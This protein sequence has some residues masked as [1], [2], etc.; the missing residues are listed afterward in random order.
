MRFRRR[1][2]KAPFWVISVL[3]L[4]GAALLVA[5][6]QWR[7][8]KEEDAQGDLIARQVCQRTADLLAGRLQK[9]FEAA[10]VETIEGIDHADL[11]ECRLPQVAPHL[12]AGQTQLPYV[13]RFFLWNERFP[14]A[15]HD[16]VLFYTPDDDEAAVP[17]VDE[18]GVALG[19]LHAEP[20]MGHELLAL[21][22]SPEFLRQT[23][24]LTEREYG[25][26]FYQ[27][28]M[29]TYGAQAWPEDTPGIIGFMV[30]LDDMK[31]SGLAELSELALAHAVEPDVRVPPLHVTLLDDSETR[32]YGPEILPG[33]SFG[34]ASIPLAFFP[35]EVPV[36]WAGPILE[37]PRWTMIVSPQLP[38]DALTSQDY[39]SGA[40]ML[41]ILVALVCAVMLHRQSSH[42][43]RMHVDFVANVTHQLKTPLSLLCAAAE[44][45]E[46]NRVTE[47]QRLREYVTLIGAHAGRLRNL[48]ERVLH[49]SMVDASMV[50]LHREPIDLCTVV[51]RS[52]R[53]FTVSSANKGTSISTVTPEGSVPVY[54]DQSA[55]EDVL[56]NLLENAVTYSRAGGIVNVR[57]SRDGDEARIVVEDNG[58][59]IDAKDLPRI[60]DKFYRSDASRSVAPGFGI[61]LAIVRSLVEAHGGR[62]WVESEKGR[63]SRFYVGLA[64][65]DE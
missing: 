21:A 39:L 45:I 25:G 43:S 52:V 54:G 62:V 24:I 36:R 30:N 49:F 48:V 3:C 13:D 12:A 18:E 61:G 53:E 59:G 33:T 19:G 10:M 35:T 57:V 7:H 65:H 14:T 58:V 4:V 63:G 16:Q 8:A 60:F 56:T 6:L 32:V 26:A 1:T 9:L 34:S 44:T 46:L 22:H 2:T 20:G 31:S 50:Q 42:L 55:L 27:V 37:V 23:L 64:V 28:V 11:R 29:H 5:Y 17:I 51:D 41:L 15:F 40:V 47:P 38:Q